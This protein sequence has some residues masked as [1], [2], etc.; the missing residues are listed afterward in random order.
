[1]KVALICLPFNSVLNPSLQIG[2][3]KACLVQAGIEAQTFHLN[4][5]LARQIGFTQYETLGN[6]VVPTLGEWLASYALFGDLEDEHAFIARWSDTFDVIRES[7]GWTNEDIIRVRRE[8]V[9]RFLDWCIEQVPWHEYGVVG[10][11]TTFQQNIISL[12]LAKRVKERFPQI[13]IVFGGANVLGP[14]GREHMRAWTW[15]D[16]ICTGEGDHALPALVRQLETGDIGSGVKGFLSRKGEQILDPGPAPMVTNLDELPDPDYDEFYE[17]QRSLG[18]DFAREFPGVLTALPMET[19]RGCWWGAKH[20]CKFCGLP[21]L[22]M[23]FRS[24]SV[25]NVIA[26]LDRLSRRYRTWFFAPVDN[27]IDNRYITELF[28]AMAREGYDYELWYESKANVTAEQLRLLRNGGLAAIQPG[29]E[30]LSSNV[31]RIMDKGVTALTNVNTMKWSRYL[32]IN[33]TWNII[34]GFPGETA[35]NYA[36]MLDLMKKIVHL[37]PPGF[38]GRIWLQRFSPY[39]EH[40]EDYPIRNRRPF[41]FYTAIYPKD[42]V[43]LNEVAYWFEYEM[44]GTQPDEVTQPIRDQVQAWK[45]RWTQQPLPALTYLKAFG[46]LQI[47]DARGTGQPAV[48]EI[49]GDMAEVLEFCQEKP[50]KFSTICEYIKARRGGSIPSEMRV[51]GALR[52]LVEL[53]LVLE[54]EEQYLSI[55]LPTHRNLEAHRTASR[56]QPEVPGMLAP[57]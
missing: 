47:Y 34:T 38:S 44:D 21:A 41:S 54:E 17:R 31:L 46:R 28:G 49:S 12:A 3:L 40:P 9:P 2:L 19:A 37:Q 16:H 4:L 11:T 48:Y 26:Q 25:P 7:L 51:R 1:V 55:V 14:M 13:Q 57:V 6:P 22:G 42:Q 24:R 52:R 32:G 36:H 23:K 10:F 30:S 56:L 5:E 39:F 43:D 8:A 27:I 50:F 29:I 20:H 15:I 33:V 18:F 53:G 45:E 35:E